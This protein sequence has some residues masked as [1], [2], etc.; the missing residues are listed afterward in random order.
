MSHAA[1]GSDAARAARPAR[2]RR[3]LCET[4][5][6]ASRP[7][8]ARLGPAR[9][10]LAVT[11]AIWRAL[12]RTAASV[13]L[14]RFAAGGGLPASVEVL[15]LAGDGGELGR[16]QAGESELADALAAPV[17][18]RLWELPRAAADHG[19][20]ALE[21]RRALD[22]ARRQP[23]LRAVRADPRRHTANER[24]ST[25]RHV[26]RHVAS[27]SVEDRRSR[28]RALRQ[29]NRPNRPREGALLRQTLPPGRLARQAA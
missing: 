20:A 14:V 15:A 19:D 11:D 2:A 23:R 7:D 25:P 27:D 5:R 12:E 28:L 3:A 26:A 13:A 29:A 18:A 24:A 22:H 16:W 21:R 6:V 4:A 1:G 9:R 8:A 17:W 10:E